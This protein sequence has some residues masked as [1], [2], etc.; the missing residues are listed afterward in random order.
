MLVL[1][2]TTGCSASSFDLWGDV[3][4][5]TYVAT[6]LYDESGKAIGGSGLAFHR[7]GAAV[8]IEAEADGDVARATVVAFDPKLVE[9][10]IGFPG[11]A[12][13]RAQ[14]V[15]LAEPSDARIEGAV[16]AGALD[17]A[18]G[19]GTLEVVDPIPDLTTSWLPDCATLLSPNEVGTM[20][21]ACRS[22]DCG[23]KVTQSGCN[24]EV[25]VE[26]CTGGMLSGEVDGTGAVDFER[27]IV[28]G[29]CRTVPTRY[30]ARATFECSGGLFEGAQCPMDLYG[31]PP[32]PAFDVA[33]IS[34][35]PGA[36]LEETATHT[37]RHTSGMVLLDD[38]VVVA[39]NERTASPY[40]CV[41][42][43]TSLLFFDPDTLE[44]IT[45]A[46]GPPCLRFLRRDPAMN[47][48]VGVDRDGVVRFDERGM[49]VATSTF[50]VPSNVYVRDL[51]VDPM[52]REALVLLTVLA[53]MDG[54]SYVL[55]FDVETLEPR[56]V[57]E[58]PDDDD[59]R[60]IDVA[61]DGRVFV[62][63]AGDDS[64]YVIDDGA[65][66]RINFRAG[67]GKGRP[68]TV[69]FDPGSGRAIVAGRGDLQAA[70]LVELSGELTCRRAKMFEHSAEALSIAPWP[71]DPN[72]VLV[73]FDS[74]E[75]TFED[76]ALLAF[77]ETD[78]MR[79]RPGAI[80]IGEGPV[81]ELAVR[82]DGVIFALLPWRDELVTVR[83][84]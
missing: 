81:S 21:E 11:A 19:G 40:A 53:R 80:E 36:P 35:G 52:R 66:Q 84:R 31:A 17:L 54:A 34:T 59:T 74:N 63:E 6:V 42:V 79:V 4:D 72:L 28:F 2:I 25:R 83:P 14:P 70:L 77:V 20:D 26:R 23:T 41:N 44:S 46:V 1:S 57:Y 65:T 60:S 39:R 62:V 50:A 29:Q 38:A 33:R 22:L 12:E 18:A 73:G 43:P 71:L 32:E 45:A 13:A 64:L 27:S 58:Q 55:R 49:V 75:E 78:N 69:R 16:W 51:A 56:G 76:R 3:P 24:L 61:P 47:A 37:A 48:F 9:A 30:D 15:T 67:C 8:E 7:A 68:T 82:D 5:D 10:S